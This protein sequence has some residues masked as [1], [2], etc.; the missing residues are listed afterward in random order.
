MKENI[1]ENLKKNYFK[2]AFKSLIGSII[3]FSTCYIPLK[4]IFTEELSIGQFIFTFMIIII[5]F[6]L[7]ILTFRSF[8]SSISNA[9]N[10]KNSSLYEIFGDSQKIDN[11]I[12]EMKQN[13]EYEDNNI[14][15]SKEYLL[16]KKDYRQL[17]KFDDILGIYESI[18]KTNNI[19]DRFSIVIETKYGETFQ[20]N[21][22]KGY[23]ELVEKLI[24]IISSRSKNAKVGF[25]KETIDY[26][27]ENT[28]KK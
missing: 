25:T 20:Y 21:Y 18:H 3:F 13:H 23:H 7:G 11:I 19:P 5:F 16:D 6:I 8:L 15:I 10:L 2:D 12:N 1:E 28:I 22:K 27:E 14:I 9:I 4:G 17:V 26:I 24:A